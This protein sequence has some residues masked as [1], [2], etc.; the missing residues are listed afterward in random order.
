MINNCC[1]YIAILI[2]IL[3]IVILHFVKKRKESFSTKK[4]LSEVYIFSPFLLPDCGNYYWNFSKTSACK[5]FKNKLKKDFTT[6]LV[7]LK[8]IRDSLNIQTDKKFKWLIFYN[9]SLTGTQVKE[10]NNILEG[11]D[12]STLKK[13]TRLIISGNIAVAKTDVKKILEK[14]KD[15]ILFSL[16]RGLTLPHKKFIS[17]LYKE[18]NS[19]YS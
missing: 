6:E 1:L 16:E 10:L 4:N 7:D 8:K 3:L 18:K 15:Y 9:S 2:I 11:T 19:L 14:K 12:Y 17:N 5:E 13:K